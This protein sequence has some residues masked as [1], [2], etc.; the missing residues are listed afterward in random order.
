[1]DFKF[2]AAYEDNENIY[3][4]YRRSNYYTREFTLYL[5]VVPKEADID[6]WKPIELLTLK[7]DFSDGFQMGTA[8]SPDKTKVALLLLQVKRCQCFGSPS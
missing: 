3:M 7:R 8:V 5:N 4:L 6:K 1:M 2:M